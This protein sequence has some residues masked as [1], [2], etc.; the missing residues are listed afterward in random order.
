MRPS[1]DSGP[2]KGGSCH[3][4]ITEVKR[5]RTEGPPGSGESNGP[6]GSGGSNSPPGSGASRLLTT[7]M[8]ARRLGVSP[9]SVTDYAKAGRLKGIKPG[10]PR[11][12]WRFHPR[13]V[14][15]FIQRGRQ[16]AGQIPGDKGEPGKAD[17]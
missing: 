7:A 10:G 6:P 15:E 5:V 14:D 16:Y 13:D 4:Q 9:R 8:V 3:S 2:A 17:V 12:H 1:S 11:G